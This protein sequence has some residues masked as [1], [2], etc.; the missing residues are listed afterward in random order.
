[1]AQNR[2]TTKRVEKDNVLNKKKK[3]LKE[4]DLKKN[5]QIRLQKT[6]KKK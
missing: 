6:K 2:K 1:M 5:L 3:H 4:E